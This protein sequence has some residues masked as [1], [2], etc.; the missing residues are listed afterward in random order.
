VHRARTAVR[1]RVPD[2]T[3]GVGTNTG[4]QAAILDLEIGTFTGSGGPAPSL[5]QCEIAAARRGEG[6]V[7]VLDRFAAIPIEVRVRSTGRPT[8]T[9]VQEAP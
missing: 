2:G 9:K 7:T 6:Q 8:S 3:P 5:H 4:V 1:F